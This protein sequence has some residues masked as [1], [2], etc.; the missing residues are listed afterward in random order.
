[1]GFDVLPDQAERPSQADPE[2]EGEAVARP[3]ALLGNLDGREG[4][5][6]G[7]VESPV[8]RE[9]PGQHRTGA[10]RVD[11]LG[12]EDL[13]AKLGP[14][15]ALPARGR[16]LEAQ[17]R[18]LLEGGLERELSVD[19]GS[20]RPGR[21][22]GTARTARLPARGVGLPGGHARGRAGGDDPAAGD[23]GPGRAGAV[24]GRSRPAGERAEAAG[25]RLGVAA[26]AEDDRAAARCRGAERSSARLGQVGRRR[27][28]RRRSRGPAAGRPARR[29]AA[30]RPE[31]ERRADGYRSDQPQC[32]DRGAG[33][34]PGEYGG[35]VAPG[36]GSAVR[37]RSSAAQI[38]GSPAAPRSRCNTANASAATRP[39]SCCATY[40]AP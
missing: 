37:H 9:G 23:R 15:Q 17:A 10:E 16:G 12:A 18:E 13:D 33:V 22:P 14:G 27:G 5:G 19:L 2:H 31:A 24:A 36:V 25:A 30:T 32:G 8:I 29:P 4:V 3:Q 40:R 20:E 26:G 11:A 21:P 1:M 34:E 38:G 35:A 39:S 6:P 28:R 7:L